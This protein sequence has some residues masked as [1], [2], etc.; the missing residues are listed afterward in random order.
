MD[1]RRRF[2]GPIKGISDDAVTINTEDGEFAVPFNDI[3]RAKLLLTDKLI[4][5]AA[6][7]GLS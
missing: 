2:K 7:K 3:A 6:S 1:G 5:A 4:A